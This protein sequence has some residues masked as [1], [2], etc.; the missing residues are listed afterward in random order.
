MDSDKAS[1][2]PAQQPDPPSDAMQALP[3]EL[4]SLIKSIPEGQSDQNTMMAALL[5]IQATIGPLPPPTM[6]REYE[7]IYPGFTA[8][9]IKMIERQET[10]RQG[11]EKTTVEGNNKR[12]S[13][14]L[15]IGA[16]VAILFLIA[17]TALGLDHDTVAASVIG[18]VDIVGLTTVFV[19]G[20]R[21]Q[22]IERV[23]KR[24]IAEQ[25]K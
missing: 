13:Q 12:A 25:K 9:F 23:E 14:G 24:K 3:P 21:E 5:G 22:R 15:Y 20:R 11:L 4:A 17:A 19:V 1:L 10:H 2:D 7:E 6:L 18:G 16:V 8:S